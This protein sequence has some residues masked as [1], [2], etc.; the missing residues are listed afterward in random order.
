MD[1]KELTVDEVIAELCPNLNEYEEKEFRF[2][3]ECMFKDGYGAKMSKLLEDLRLERSKNPEQR[4]AFVQN[5]DFMLEIAKS[6]KTPPLLIPFKSVVWI[7]SYTEYFDNSPERDHFSLMTKYGYSKAYTVSVGIGEQLVEKYKK[8]VP[9]D[10][11]IGKTKE[12]KQKYDEI[13][14]PY[15]A[16]RAKTMTDGR[17]SEK[18][19]ALL[20]FFCLFPYTAM[21]G[22]NHMYLGN[23]K[24]SLL[25]IASIALL[26]ISIVFMPL[27]FV[28][29]PW[30]IFMWGWG[31]SQAL[32]AKHLMLTDSNG[33]YIV[34]KEL[35]NR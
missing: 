3:L 24:G 14:K 21:F 23:K 12:N 26:L 32:Q 1:Y 15:T 8:L 31:I 10:V 2:L 7:S 25:G 9:A 5:E 30:G 18:S 27:A 6:P 33:N 28:F 20:M 13:I 35:K 34:S 4:A 19:K 22:V 16:R 17:Y 11:M 29:I